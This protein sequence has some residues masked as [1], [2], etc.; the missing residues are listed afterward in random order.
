M[1]VEE[2]K[3]LLLVEDEA[4]I[5][6]FEK[7]ELEKCGYNVITANTGEKAV[8]A[9]K[10]NHEIDLIL[11]D[12]NLGRGIDGI[13][14][15]EIIL[16]DQGIPVVFLSSYADPKTVEKTEKI[17]SYGYVVKSAGIPVLDASIKMAFELSKISIQI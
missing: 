6:F 10:E 13:E 2:K 7:K 15:A 1:K 3:T 12:I 16:K 5:A 11:M 8:K 4:L 14:A 9:S 17:T